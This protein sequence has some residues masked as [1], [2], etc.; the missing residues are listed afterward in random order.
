MD[1]QRITIEEKGFQGCFPQ[2]IVRSL[3]RRAENDFKE[4]EEIGKEEIGKEE[5][6]TRSI[7]S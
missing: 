7:R 4:E 3:Y 6:V 1:R 2:S 5:E